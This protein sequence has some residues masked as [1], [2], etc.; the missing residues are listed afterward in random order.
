M[1]CPLYFRTAQAIS[2]KRKNNARGQ[3]RG[4]TSTGPSRSTVSK[5]RNSV[6]RFCKAMLQMRPK[7]GATASDMLL[8]DCTSAPLAAVSTFDE[9]F[10]SPARIELPS[11]TWGFHRVQVDE[12]RNVVF[13]ELQHVREP[14]CAANT[15]HIVP[16]KLLDTDMTLSVVLM[17]KLFSHELLGVSLEVSTIDDITGLLKNLEKLYL[18]GGGPMA[19][20]Y[21]H[22]QLECAF[23]DVC[24]RWR[25]K[26][27]AQIL[28]ASGSC[29][30]CAGLSDNLRIHQRRAL[31]RKQER[32]AR[33]NFRIYNFCNY[34]KCRGLEHLFECLFFF[35]LLSWSRAVDTTQRFG[36]GKEPFATN[37]RKQERGEAVRCIART[38]LAGIITGAVTRIVRE[39]SGGRRRGYPTT[40]ATTR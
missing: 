36:S 8:H 28:S 1:Q 10:E 12:L 9:L 5:A 25:H 35:C 22:T 18:C 38:G 17:R 4:M 26:K 30:R 6:T 27:C 3:L 40:G 13:S 19:K 31:L 20:E 29:Q 15:S 21:P 39:A 37:P 23:V 32:R 11:T 7:S 34:E 24:G 33:T 14:R 2:R 16:W